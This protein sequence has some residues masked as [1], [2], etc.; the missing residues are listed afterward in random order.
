MTTTTERERTDVTAPRRRRRR[1]WML[2]VTAVLLGWLGAQAI[3]GWKF[4]NNTT[5]PIVGSAMFSGPPNGAGRD[6]LVPRVYA[7]TAS[8]ARV[9]MDQ[10]TFGLE[11]FEWR[12]W[13]KRH[14]EDADDAHAKQYADQ[15]A[16]VFVGE[17]PEAPAPVAIELWRVPAL[18]EQLDHGRMVRA[19]TL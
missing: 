1:R 9:E 16:V 5:Y 3:A 15:L 7:V 6:F 10:H 14:L 12:R 8:G 4:A 18:D 17:R 11:P 2:G 13:I 19:V